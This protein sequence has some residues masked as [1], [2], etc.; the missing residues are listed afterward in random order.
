MKD[1]IAL[2]FT[3]V[4]SAF[5]TAQTLPDNMYADTTHAPFL[6]GVTSGDPLQNQLI[7]WTKIEAFAA[8]SEQV[9]KW[10]IA[11]DSFFQMNLQHGE[12]LATAQSDFTVKIDVNNLLPNTQYFYRFCNKT[13]QYSA[14]GIG[15][16]LPTAAVSKLKLAVVSCSSVWSGYFNAY[17]Q[18]AHQSAIDFVVHLGDY[19]Y[20]YADKD[21]LH[22]MPTPYPVDVSSLA[23]WRERHTYYLLDPDL[24]AARQCKTWIAVWDNH[25][26]DCEAPGTTADAIQAFYEYLPIRI[27]NVE[28]PQN[29]Y[30]KFSFGGLADL[31]MTDMFLF[32]GKEEYETNK[33]SVWG[34]QQDGWIKE[35]LKSSTAI[36]KIIG[37]QEMM[38]SWLS[39]GAPK[40][41]KLPGNGKYFDP[42]CWDG[43]PDDRARFYYFL[44]S[45]RINN[46]VVLTG[47]A[48][49]SFV[50][51]LAMNP[52]DKKSYNP[53]TGKGAVGVELVGPSITRGNMDESGVPKAFMPLVQSMSKNLNPHHVWCQFSKHGYVTLEVTPERCKAVFWYTKIL[54]KTDKQVLAKVY[55]VRK[56][57]NHW[58]HKPL[59]RKK[60]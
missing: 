39:E 6:Y 51:D 5:L 53:K 26:V 21:E 32:R 15:K 34:N 23:E 41:L 1:Y 2:I 27:S 47:D 7:I 10:E 55:E 48:H 8:E 37:N 52:T 4:V 46:T 12:V 20:D 18:I 17:R 16:T 19:V 3:L 42:G 35:Q 36:W 59:K 9:V 24:R 11:T 58:Q 56:D 28:T 54:K 30:R 38:G 13:N 50:T 33:K 22:R 45:N 25:D 57:A 43:Y 29:I 14:V 44:D 49:M 60:D 31:V 40:F